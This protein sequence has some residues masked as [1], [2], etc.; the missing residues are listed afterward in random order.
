[1]PE[2]ARAGSAQCGE[3]CL[4]ADAFRVVAEGYE[5]RAG[6]LRADS[7]LVEEALRGCRLGEGPEAIV[8]KGDLLAERLMAKCHAAHRLFHD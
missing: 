8:E 7:T 1:M 2:E 4:G 6:D 5:A 3:A